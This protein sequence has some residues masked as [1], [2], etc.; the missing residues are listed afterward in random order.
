MM[1]TVVMTCCVQEDQSVFLQRSITSSHLTLSADGAL[2]QNK[3]RHGNDDNIGPLP[4]AFYV[5]WEML[6]GEHTEFEAS[7]ILFSGLW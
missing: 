7:R 2:A 5:N 1:E 4:D 6:R 3:I